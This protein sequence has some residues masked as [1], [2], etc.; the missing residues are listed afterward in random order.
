MADSTVSKLNFKNEI[1]SYES[2][3]IGL[4]KVISGKESILSDLK[5][6][7]SQ[8][9]ENEIVKMNQKQRLFYE[10]SKKFIADNHTK[11][12]YGKDD[13]FVHFYD[14]DNEKWFLKNKSECTEQDNEISL[15]RWES[16]RIK[17]INNYY[18]ALKGEF[19]EVVEFLPEKMSS[20][21]NI[22]KYK[23]IKERLIIKGLKF[24]KR[25]GVYNYSCIFIDDIQE[26]QCIINNTVIKCDNPISIKFNKFYKRD[27]ESIENSIKCVNMLYLAERK[28]K[29]ELFIDKFYKDRRKLKFI[30]EEIKKI[31][32]SKTM[33]EK[34]V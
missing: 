21:N 26:N 9:S 12:K 1:E 28:R 2:K 25:F 3:R 6:K 14:R 10:T 19:G 34:K 8:E 7:I 17:N 20:I 29:E 23:I 32:K 33:R 5:L 24:K 27:K 22:K 11:P 13:D 18:D 30:N 31:E 15:K 16:K 4:M